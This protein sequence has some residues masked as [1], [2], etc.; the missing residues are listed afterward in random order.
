MDI[1]KNISWH[2]GIDLFPRNINCAD[3]VPEAQIIL[4]VDFFN[5]HLRGVLQVKR[6]FFFAVDQLLHKYKIK[7]FHAIL[8]VK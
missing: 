3:D 1:F 7:N 5:V 4:P 2:Q 6:F 8:T